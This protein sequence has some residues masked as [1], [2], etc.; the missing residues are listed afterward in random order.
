MRRNG[1]TMKLVYFDSE[2]FSEC[3][4]KKAGGF[5]YVTNPSTKMIMGQFAVDDA[6]V[7]VYDYSMKSKHSLKTRA[8]FFG[9]RRSTGTSSA[10]PKAS[11]FQSSARL[12]QWRLI[13]LFRFLVNSEWPLVQS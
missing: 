1:R 8:G 7:K 3:D 11:R 4:I 10:T 6:P 5:R 12:T 13:I 9:T 2:T